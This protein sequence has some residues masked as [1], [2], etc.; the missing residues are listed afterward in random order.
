MY[1]LRLEMNRLFYILKAK[2]HSFTMYR[3]DQNL[4]AVSALRNRLLLAIL[5]NSA[6]NT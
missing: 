1:Y 2:Q 4:A 5:F 3:T 6:R